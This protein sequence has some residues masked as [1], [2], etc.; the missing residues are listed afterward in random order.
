MQKCCALVYSVHACQKWTI[1][2]VVCIA[3]N[4]T[5]FEC[6]LVIIKV[7]QCVCVCVLY[8]VARN[9]IDISTSIESNCA[10]KRT[11]VLLFKCVQT[12]IFGTCT[13]LFN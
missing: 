12:G 5:L 7:N 13:W 10:L 1:Q 4:F 2:V 8:C 9:R 6:N 3:N 11:A